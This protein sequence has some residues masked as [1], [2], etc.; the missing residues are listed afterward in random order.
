MKKQL[1]LLSIAALFV[2]SCAS[3]KDVRIVGDIKNIPDS[4]IIELLKLEGNIYVI[5]GKTYV[6]DGKFEFILQ[7]DSLIL[8]AE[9]IISA[10]SGATSSS[11][12]F[13]V[14]LGTTNIVGDSYYCSLWSVTNDTPEQ[15]EKNE[16]NPIDDLAK[17]S[18]EY[19]KKYKDIMDTLMS[20]DFTGSDPIVIRYK[21]LLKITDSLY[22]AKELNIYNKLKDKSPLSNLEIGEYRYAVSSGLKYGDFLKP[23]IEDIKAKY[24]SFSEE[25][26]KSEQGQ[27]ISNL[28]YPI[29]IL[30]IGD[31]VPE[32]ELY[33]TSGVKHPI[34]EFKGKYILLD[35]WSSGCGPCIAA[36]P[37]LKEIQKT[38][39][40]SLVIIG[41][42]LDNE[43]Y[44][45]AAT[46]NHGISWTNLSD[47]KGMN[48]G[49]S[50]N[51]GFNGI[52][53]YAIVNPEGVIT[54][55]WGGYG[56]GELKKRIEPILGKK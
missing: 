34:S 42:S 46:E 3:F 33:D 47:G 50:A 55:T 11:N 51:F 16:L 35:F 13:W 30:T 5:S 49:F 52:P 41:I 53:F 24:E 21:N 1:L 37:E 36:S 56:E 23:Y 9:F 2:A 12:T 44:W 54:N 40:D 48:S 15:K 14:N 39:S 26:K 18:A 29:K 7:P 10:D 6:K 27:V 17:V 45:K 22:K 31:T 8:P 43:K 28:I 19:G 4:T 20:G 25:Q 38:Y 32:G